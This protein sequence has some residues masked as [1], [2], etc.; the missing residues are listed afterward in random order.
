MS[1][2][3]AL[4]EARRAAGLSIDDV[5]AKSRLRATVIRAIEND[6][7][8]LCGGDFYA[9]AHL[10]MLAAIVGADGQALVADYDAHVADLD[11]LPVAA[12]IH[13]N[14]VQTRVITRTSQRRA[15]NWGAA[16]AAAV[17]IVIIV[18]VG[19]QLLGHPG[20]SNKGKPLAGGSTPSASVSPSP[21]QQ[22]S[23]SVSPTPTQNSTPPSPPTS[24]VAQAGVHIVLRIT[25]AKCWVL[26]TGSDG[27]VI[28]Q[29]VLSPG[30]VQT[31][32]DP[33]RIALKLGN[34][35]ATDLTV[36]GVHVGAPPSTND[37]ASFT[38]PPGDP[39]KALG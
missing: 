9:R 3:Q 27:G 18:V 23:T 19:A 11:E 28:Y 38:F 15:P 16:A 39:T 2:G 6:D 14:E 24:A 35:P 30:Q 25:T 33:Q 37:V 29:G 13:D 4:S 36:N 5:S 17:L 32:S 12:Q 10:R 31:F 21:S 8:S 26:A 1:I 7:F 20:S 34:A 22:P